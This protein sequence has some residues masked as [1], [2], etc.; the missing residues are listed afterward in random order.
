MVG[1]GGQ[2]GGRKF[3]KVVRKIDRERE[4]EKIAYLAD[5]ATSVLN[6]N[7]LIG[8]LNGLYAALCTRDVR[9]SRLAPD[10]CKITSRWCRYPVAHTIL[11]SL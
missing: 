8:F 1:G 11:R 4:R 2:Q 3:S 7:K 5:T 10:E 6:R 9:A